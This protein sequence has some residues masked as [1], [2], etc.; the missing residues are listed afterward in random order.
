MI[1]WSTVLPAE[2]RALT[3]SETVPSVSPSGGWVTAAVNRPPSPAVAVT[4]SL[5]LSPSSYDASTVAVTPSG[6]G[7]P[8]WC[9]TVNAIS[10][11][12]PA[13]AREPSSRARS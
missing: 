3:R 8:C 5:Q 11:G 13:F 1:V 12:L 4:G 6:A 9:A 10:Y 2:S 7:A